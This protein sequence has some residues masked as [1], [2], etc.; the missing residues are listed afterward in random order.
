MRIFK[1]STV[2]WLFIAGALGISGSL[3]QAQDMPNSYTTSKNLALGAIHSY[4]FRGVLGQTVSI[5]VGEIDPA[6]TPAFEVYN[7]AGALMISESGTVAAMQLEFELPSTDQYRIDVFESG[8]NHAGFYEFHFHKAPGADEGGTLAAADFVSGTLTNG[9]IDAFNF[10]ASAGQSV[11]ISVGEVAGSA[12]I[13]PAW[14]LFD[15]DGA[16]VQRKTGTVG[17][18]DIEVSLLSDGQYTL[19]VYESGGN[20]AGDYE[21]HIARSPGANE[22][23]VLSPGVSVSEFLTIGDIDSYT[24]IGVAGKAI[25]FSM[26][27]TAS[28][29]SI[30][31]LIQIFRPG[32][33]SLIQS[34]GTVS[35]ADSNVVLPDSGTYTVVAADSGANHAGA[36]TLVFQGI[37]PP[38]FG[39]VKLLSPSGSAGVLPVYQWEAISSATWYLLWVEN[40]ASA[41]QGSN[42]TVHRAWYTAAQLG[43]SSGSGICQ[44]SA[45]KNIGGS[46]VRW[47][48][49][50]WN[51]VIGTGIWSLPLSYNSGFGPNPPATNLMSPNGAGVG[52]SPTY[53]WESRSTATY[54]NL[55]IQDSSAVSQPRLYL[56]LTAAQAGCSGGG[57][58]SYTPSISVTGESTWWV[59]TYGQD[60][61]VDLYGSWSAPQSFTP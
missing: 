27:E 61:G 57:T 15:P 4:K 29:S 19:M 14:V 34:S 7:S 52:S 26:A 21:L 11:S 10:I 42:G 48:V 41:E 58:C 53:S 5:G 46:V 47:W 45:P 49:Q 59:M 51:S 2:L 50:P 32:G 3:A 44:V 25:S 1:A 33:S 12:A 13:T 37:E 38:D 55:Y 30:T 28:S 54:Y 9:D 35:A 20:H 40:E 17:A 22:L 6:L 56:W 18:A 23:G 16:F 60:S 36:Y 43:C 8:L 24:F 31:P 39:P